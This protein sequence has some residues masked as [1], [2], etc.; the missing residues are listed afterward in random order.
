MKHEKSEN[1]VEC[2]IEK[3]DL[4]RFV[5][6][7]INHPKWMRECYGVVSDHPRHGR[8]AGMF[9]LFVVLLCEDEKS[10]LVEGSLIGAK[11]VIDS[12]AVVSIVRRAFK[13][14]P[15]ILEKKK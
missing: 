11:L 7:D 10:L 5:R 3:G 14:R 12:R 6:G 13:P 2:Y 15:A 1:H 4:I 9:D 8:R